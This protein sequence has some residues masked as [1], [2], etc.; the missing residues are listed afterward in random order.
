MA[1]PFPADG[2]GSHSEG[3]VVEFSANGRSWVGN[4]QRG[5]APLSTVIEHP[6]G[7]RAI[8]VAGGDGYLVDPNDPSRTE[9]IRGAYIE[10]IEAINHLNMVLVGNGLAFEAWN[11]QGVCWKSPRISW[12]GIRDVVIKGDQLTGEAYSSVDNEWHHFDL[13]LVT[14]ACANGVYGAQ[15]ANARRIVTQ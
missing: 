7:Y 4:F 2:R 5:S 8:V 13:D 15:I 14:G 11:V 10:F 9:L 6:D 3:L 12:D 1:L